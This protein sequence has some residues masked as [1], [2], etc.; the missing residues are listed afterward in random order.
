MTGIEGDYFMG[1]EAI[2][3]LHSVGNDG[4]DEGDGRLSGKWLVKGSP[5]DT[6]LQIFHLEFKEELVFDGEVSVDPF[7]K[8]GDVQHTKVCFKGVAASCRGH[9]S[10]GVTGIKFQFDPLGCPEKEREFFNGEG[11]IAVCA[12]A[13]PSHNSRLEVDRSDIFQGFNFWQLNPLFVGLTRLFDRRRR[14]P[15]VLVGFREV[16]DL[17]EGIFKKRAGGSE[18]FTVHG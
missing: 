6:A 1:R 8:P 12:A 16:D 15:T 13:L 10:E 17:A 14:N 7:F 9:C 5:S 18:G 4:P 11:S 3:P 2:A